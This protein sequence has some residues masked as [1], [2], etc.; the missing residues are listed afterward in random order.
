MTTEKAETRA[1]AGRLCGDMGGEG[2][3]RVGD[4]GLSSIPSVPISG[5]RGREGKK[6][7]FGGVNRGRTREI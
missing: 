3:G 6:D 1:W 4:T 2:G 5:G 7:Q